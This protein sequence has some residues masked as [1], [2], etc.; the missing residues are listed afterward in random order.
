MLWDSY[1]HRWMWVNFVSVFVK[2]VQLYKGVTFPNLALTKVSPD[3]TPFKLRFIS[4][5]VIA[6]Y[7]IKPTRFKYF[8]ENVV[9]SSL[10]SLYISKITQ[11]TQPQKCTITIFNKIIEN[12]IQI[13]KWRSDETDNQCSN[14]IHHWAWQWECFY[15]A[16]FIWRKHFD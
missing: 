11:C 14:I 7:N 3:N 4:R 15:F 5:N 6:F 12:K 2:N 9:I 1:L 8:V 10:F 16:F 13:I